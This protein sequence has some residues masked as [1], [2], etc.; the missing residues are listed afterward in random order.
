[1]AETRRRKLRRRSSREG[2]AAPACPPVSESGAA[3]SGYKSARPATAT[4]TPRQGPPPLLPSLPNPPLA[5]MHSVSVLVV[6]LL[7]AAVAAAGTALSPAPTSSPA[8]QSRQVSAAEAAAVAKEKRGTAKAAAAPASSARYV[9]PAVQQQQQQQQQS[10][11]DT[12]P[13][14]VQYLQPEQL[15]LLPQQQLAFLPPQYYQQPA[16]LFYQPQQQQLQQQQPVVTYYQ[17]PQQQPHQALSPQQL[18]AKY[19]TAPRA[20]I[21]AS[22]AG[23][24]VQPQLQAPDYSQ[25]GLGAAASAAAVS[26]YSQLAGLGGA[27][28]QQSPVFGPNLF[29][30]QPLLMYI[31]DAAA[32]LSY[33]PAATAAAAPAAGAVP[34]GRGVQIYQSPYLAQI[35]SSLQSQAQQQLAAY[36]QQTLSPA[37]QLLQQ[38]HQPQ[39][40]QQLQQQAH[41]QAVQVK[42]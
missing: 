6:S 42:G 17:Q 26:P 34:Q 9:A 15:Q 10:Q 19:A 39:G 14:Q 40:A 11:L 5:A 28:L 2:D 32:G 41:P 4:V 25:L 29:Q 22:V 24:A 33:Q 1:M 23:T 18:Y 27:G 12:Q 7:V 13:Q 20:G 37:Q 3:G 31:P 16:Q 30:H 36:L 21:P 38:V 8:A 35:Q